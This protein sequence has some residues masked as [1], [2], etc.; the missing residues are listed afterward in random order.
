MRRKLDA[1]GEE[2]CGERWAGEGQALVPRS[3]DAKMI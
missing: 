3:L 1:A 2:E